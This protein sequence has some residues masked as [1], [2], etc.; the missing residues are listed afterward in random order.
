MKKITILFFLVFGLF[1]AFQIGRAYEQKNQDK[2][3]NTNTETDQERR[4]L[5]DKENFNP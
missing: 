3:R 5:T 2:D 1:V 4:Y